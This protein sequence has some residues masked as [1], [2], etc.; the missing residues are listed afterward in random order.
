MHPINV[1]KP[2]VNR[3]ATMF[4]MYIS[5]CISPTPSRLPANK[6]EREPKIF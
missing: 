5:E 1:M 3:Y 6:C 4:P 2:H